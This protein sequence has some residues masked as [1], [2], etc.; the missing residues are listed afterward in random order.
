MKARTEK[1]DMGGGRNVEREGRRAGEG[2]SKV[3]RSVKVT[4]GR[5]NTVEIWSENTHL[6]KKR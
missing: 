4:S 5:D 3:Y 2:R 6:G 1:R